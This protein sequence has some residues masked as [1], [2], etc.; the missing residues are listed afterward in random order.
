MTENTDTKKT[1]LE[2]MRARL[3]A[4]EVKLRIRA[5]KQLTKDLIDFGKLVMKAGLTALPHNTL[6]GALLFLKEELGKSGSDNMLQTWT[7]LAEEA[8]TEEKKSSTGIIII[9]ASEVPQD[10]KAQLKQHGL[11]WN[12]LRKEWYG[13]VVELEGLKDCIGTLEYKLEIIEKQE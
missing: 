12:S 11:K 4:E 3:A 5:E 10:I 8:T 6:Y 13:H 1:K 9:F 7:K 2:Q